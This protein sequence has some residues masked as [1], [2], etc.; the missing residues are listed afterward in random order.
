VVAF[1]LALGLAG[2][3]AAGRFLKEF[4]FETSALD[5][6]TFLA[7]LLV[8]VGAAL[9]ASFLP[10]RRAASIDPTKALRSE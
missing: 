7:A 2:S 3:V 6:V 1:G 10:A 4:L 9:I 5:P 8:L